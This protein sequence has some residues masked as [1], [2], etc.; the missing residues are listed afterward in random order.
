M[1]RPR[2]A[3]LDY[4]PF[5]VDFFSDEKVVCICQYCGKRGGI[6][7]LD[8]IVPFSKGGSDDIDNLATSC[9]HCNRQKRDK[10]LEEFRRWKKHSNE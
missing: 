9:R 7:E 3:G 6:L 8:H 4:F 1:A 10:S 5:D 2:K